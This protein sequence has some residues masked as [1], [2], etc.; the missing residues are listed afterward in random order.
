[1]PISHICDTCGKESL[2]QPPSSWA[3]VAANLTRLSG[4]PDNTPLIESG[5]LYV[6]EDHD[7]SGIWLALHN[8]LAGLP[9]AH[10]PET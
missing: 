6:C 3:I 4:P 5:V 1:M 2:V 8:G 7:Q 10:G 9:P